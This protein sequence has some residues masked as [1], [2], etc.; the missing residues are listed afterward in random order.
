MSAIFNFF[1]GAESKGD[2][3][4]DEDD[5][6]GEE[7]EE[8]NKSKSTY[9]STQAISDKKRQERRLEK[10]EK[11]IEKSLKKQKARYMD[12]KFERNG[13]KASEIDEMKEAFK[14][15]DENGDGTISPHEILNAMASL[16]FQMSHSRL[17]REF[18]NK[19]KMCREEKGEQGIYFE[20]FLDIVTESMLHN[21]EDNDYRH[22]F[23]IFDLDHNGFISLT[24]LKKVAHELGETLTD[25]ELSEMLNQADTNRDGQVDF[26]EFMDVVTKNSFVGT[27]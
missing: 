9:F 26:N 10:E 2:E 21:L 11:R 24:N 12:L 4:G 14:L 19:A 20:D 13:V 25:Y 23:K 27:I 5:D 3:P 6:D 16:G 1:F 22:I 8:G 18:Q 15:F 17:L 7:A